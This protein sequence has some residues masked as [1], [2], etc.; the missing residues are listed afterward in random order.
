M[1]GG[2]V[3]DFK[4]LLLRGDLFGIAAAL[5]LALATFFFLQMLVEGLIG[6]AIAAVFSEP[7]LYA[8]SFSVNHAEFGYG[9]VLSALIM[10]ALAIAIV[11]LVSRA[12]EGADGRS[13][14]A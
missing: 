3:N 5:L 12:R 8:L 13:S 2:I 14:D 7:G 1:F 4:R 6:P 9:S 10:L 11:V